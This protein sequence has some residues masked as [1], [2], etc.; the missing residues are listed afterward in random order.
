MSEELQFPWPGATATGIGSVPGTDPLA[1]CRMVFDELPELPHVPEL[2]NRGP[3]ADI[4]GR[5]ASLL[6]DMPVQT[7]SRGWQLADRPGRD[8]IRAASYLSQD[9]DVL[10][11]VADGYAGPLKI[12][13]CGPW[14]LAAALELTHSANPALSDPGA[15]A[16]L[17]ESLAEGLAA[18]AADVRKRV[19]G[20][21]LIVQ[22]DEPSLPLALAGRV[23]TASG[24]GVVPAIDAAV[25]SQRLRSVLSAPAAYTVVHCCAGATPFPEI[26]AAGAAAVSFDLARLP[27]R[28]IDRVAEA[29]EDGLGIFAGALAAESAKR[30]LTGPQLSPRQTAEQVVTLW[31]RTGLAPGRLTEQ[32]VITPA[33]GLAGVSP[34]AARAALRHCREAARITPEMIEPS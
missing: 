29:A 19:P 2:P 16:D 14:T 20:A 1:A 30:L 23:P 13:I 31:R 9:L 7:T 26:K 25:A 11:E 22:V 33:C 15:V 4:I 17:V 28:E 21:S 18:H 12:Q 5:T 27:D 24:L 6:V 34:A 3:G 32:V 10:E 8:M